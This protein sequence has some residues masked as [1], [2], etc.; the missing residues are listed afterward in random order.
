MLGL[1]WVSGVADVLDLLWVLQ[2][3]RQH[4]QKKTRLSHPTATMSILAKPSQ[5]TSNHD[6]MDTQKTHGARRVCSITTCNHEWRTASHHPSRPKWPSRGVS[7]GPPGDCQKR[8]TAAVGACME[9]WT[10]VFPTILQHRFESSGGCRPP[11]L[12]AP[13]TW[14]I[15]LRGGGTGSKAQHN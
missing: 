12:W 2:T 8:C 3:R 6:K 15:V 5:P 11:R 10:A 13:H 14:G 1:P 7:P 9:E 4:K